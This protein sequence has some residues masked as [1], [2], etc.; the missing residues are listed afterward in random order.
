MLLSYMRED[1]DE[2]WQDGNFLEHEILQQGLLWG[3]GRM[4]LSRR[5]LMLEKGM[6]LDLPPY[7]DSPDATVRGLAARAIGILGVPVRLERIKELC[8]DNDTMRLYEDGVLRTF[9]VGQLAD[10]ALQ[11]LAD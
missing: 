9:S 8:R 11:R 7:L 4:A 5:K 2:I 6:D 3:A 1:G 10:Q